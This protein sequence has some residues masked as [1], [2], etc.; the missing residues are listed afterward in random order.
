L[1]R[2]KLAKISAKNAAE[3]KRNLENRRLEFLQANAKKVERITNRPPFF[4]QTSQEMKGKYGWFDSTGKTYN[5]TEYYSGWVFENE[6]KYKE[7]L[8]I[9]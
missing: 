4:Y 6:E 2:L 7:F 5:L 8:N 1:E 9:K 3:E